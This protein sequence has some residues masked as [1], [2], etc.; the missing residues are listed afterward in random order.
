MAAMA[1]LKFSGKVVDYPEFKKLFEECVEN[2]YE[3]YATIMI[4]REQALPQSLASTVPRCT[5]L[6]SVW[7]K[8]DKKFLDPARVWR[9]VKADLKSLKRDSMGKKEVKWLLET[10][11][12]KEQVMIIS[13]EIIISVVI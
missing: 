1:I 12:N 4:L 10:I 2:Q 5:D 8:L 6:V 7:E 3:E 9:G 11:K 13:T